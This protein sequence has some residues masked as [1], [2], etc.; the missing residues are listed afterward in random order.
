MR[1]LS[2]RF[3][4]AVLDPLD[5]WNGELAFGLCG[6]AKSLLIRSASGSVVLPIVC[7]TCGSMNSLINVDLKPISLNMFD[8]TASVFGSTTE[9]SLEEGS[10]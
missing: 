7:S 5:C 8:D 9:T 10:G 3:V 4:P 6:V 1:P 2:N